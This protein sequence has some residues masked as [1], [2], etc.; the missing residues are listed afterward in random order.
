MECDNGKYSIWG[1]QGHKG[2]VEKGVAL[3]Y[4]GS[5]SVSERGNAGGINIT[6][7]PKLVYS[8]F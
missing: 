3:G 7:E 4:V 6:E 1:F 5:W 2:Q 8:I